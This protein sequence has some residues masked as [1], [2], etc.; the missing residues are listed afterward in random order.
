MKKILYCLLASGLILFG[1]NRW[2]THMED[3]NEDPENMDELTVSD[4]FSWVTSSTVKFVLS[5]VPGGLV[6]ITTTDGNIVFH[7]GYNYN[8]S[9]DYIINVTLPKYV[10]EVKIN[11]VVIPIL[12][13][14][15][16]YSFGSSK[17]GVMTDFS[18]SFD[19]TNDY[20]RINEDELIEEY[21]FTMAAWIKTSGF[22]DPNEDM[23]IMDQ[24]DPDK[25][26]RYYGI[27]I[28]AGEGGKA[29]IRARA[30]SSKTAVGT[31]VLTDDQWHF[32]V[33]VF[34]GKNNRKLYV[35]GVLEASDT[36]NVSFK[37]SA[38]ETVFGRWGDESP[39]S[40][41][42]GN[43][44]DVQLWDV[45]LSGSQ[46]T[47]Y[48][49]NSPTGNE[50]GLV[51]F[52]NFNNGWG[53]TVYDQTSEENDGTIYGATWVSDA[54]GGNDN[55]GDGITNDL[56]DYPD[57]PNRAFNNFFPAT[58]YGSLAFE[59]LWPGT[60]D[61]DFNDVVVDYQFKTVT[62]ASNYVVEIF[63]SFVARAS[64]ATFQNGMGFEFPNSNVAGSDLNVSGSVLNV[65][66]ITTNSNGTEAGQ[67]KNT[68]IVFDNFFEVI[69]N[70]GGETG[71]NTDPNG[72]FV[73]PDTVTITMTFTANTY[74]ENDVYISNFNPFIFVN[75]VRSKEIHLADYAPTDLADTTFFGTSHDDSNPSAGRYY[76]TD[77]NLPWGINIYESFDY[78]QEKKEIIQAYLKFG[79][80]ASS[81]GASYPDWYQDNSGYRNTGFIY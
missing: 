64:G 47:N 27:Y 56:D 59:D 73:S 60:G 25:S 79:S 39:N 72:V 23:V 54:G 33:G 19:G 17:M 22:S 14:L 74:T 12:G 43:I 31:T 11:N 30:G 50:S 1:C 57:D 8:S 41:F 34:S 32:V 20:V 46:I 6:Q 18:L 15:V 78:P 29:C 67:S 75:M 77:G 81:S 48:Y 70:T 2:E 21:P 53:S 37:E 36:R 13:S 5:N 24:A 9:V 65:G 49:N 42:N 69:P 44:D 58:G 16:T 55:D 80:W 3:I 51:G 45:A 26:N 7:K 63:G 71:V 28:G 61:Y 4:D 40:Y 76:K 38:E 62:N 68:V 52:W 35:D 10:S 66:F